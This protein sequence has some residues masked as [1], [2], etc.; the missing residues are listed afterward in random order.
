MDKILTCIV[1]LESQYFG[2]TQREVI[3]NLTWFEVFHIYTKIKSKI[4]KTY[5]KE[6]LLK[7]DSKCWQ[8]ISKTKNTP[9]KFLKEF[10]HK[11]DWNLV[12]KHHDITYT[13]LKRFVNFLDFNIINQRCAVS[14]EN[15]LQ[16]IRMKQN[17]KKSILSRK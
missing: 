15:I 9:N 8:H 16:I 10:V 3:E 12:S 14:K 11:M 6:K 7:Y 1:I 4:P 5:L 2:Y 17:I 13:L